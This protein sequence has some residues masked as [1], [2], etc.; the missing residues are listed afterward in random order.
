MRS[1]IQKINEHCEIPGVTGVSVFNKD[2]IKIFKD[3]RN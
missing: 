1:S 2:I 3:K